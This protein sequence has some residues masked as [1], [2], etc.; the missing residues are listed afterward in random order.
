MIIML[1]NLTLAQIEH[2]IGIT[3]SD[4]HREELSKVRQDAVNTTPLGEGCWHGFDI[5]F[6]IVADTKKTAS[7][8]RDIFIQYEPSK[9]HETLQ[10]TWEKE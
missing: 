6:M 4:E 1:G 7:R 8:I 9:W 2:R 10:V 3:L 5:P